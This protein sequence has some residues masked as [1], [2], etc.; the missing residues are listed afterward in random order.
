MNFLKAI[1]P[2]ILSL[3]T[4]VSCQKL[5]SNVTSSSDTYSYLDD[6]QNITTPVDYV[7]DYNF[8]T[9][10][11]NLIGE[12]IPYI[13]NSNYNLV[14]KKSSIGDSILKALIYFDSTEKLN[15][16]CEDYSKICIENGFTV[17]NEDNDEYYHATKVIDEENS[18]GLELQ[19][20]CGL[21]SKNKPCFGIFA[22]NYLH[23]DQK[24]WPSV[25]P[26]K[27]LGN[28]IPHLEENEK[29]I[30]SAFLLNDSNLGNYVQILHYG[31]DKD[32]LISYK[33]LY[34]KEDFFIE[35]HTSSNFGYI[36]Y[37]KNSKYCVNF[38]YDE[39]CNAINLYIFK[40]NN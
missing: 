19:F 26:I 9:T 34:E 32:T 27:L 31:V 12:V 17:E 16:S 18:K 28:D 35:D 37:E 10:C 40:N 11:I 22:F 1:F 7:W 3:L 36:A 33:E 30:Y 39:S 6:F 13:E 14:V 24:K 21:D 4:I 2:S 20:L 23:Y 38:L 5:D 8:D 15:Q 29:Y 25:F